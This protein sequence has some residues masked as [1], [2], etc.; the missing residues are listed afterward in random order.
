VKSRGKRWKE[1][2]VIGLKNT[3]VKEGSESEKIEIEI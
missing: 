3:E 1:R 2:H